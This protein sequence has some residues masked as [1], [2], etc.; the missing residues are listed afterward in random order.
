MTEEELNEIPEVPAEQEEKSS[1]SYIPVQQT[2]VKDVALKVSNTWNSSPLTLLWTDAAQFATLV[3]NYSL[4]LAD[5]ALAEFERSPL[6]QE[7]INLDKKIDKSIDYVK[8]YLNEEFGRENAVSHYVQ[9]GIEKIHGTYKFPIDR[10][11]RKTA[12]AKMIY[13]LNH[14]NIQGKYS[15][16]YWTDIKNQYDPLVTQAQDIDGNV[17]DKVGIKDEYK[18]EIIKT[19][20]AIVNL[21]KANYPDKF[22]HELIKW[23][24][25]RDKY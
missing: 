22:K 8:G 24:F 7:L 23:G 13:S 20:R 19:L 12:L 10:N 14:Y 6:T 18:E 11:E 4:S 5:R 16:V 3:Q 15:E 1:T 21:L 9:F 25:Q 2:D 17:S